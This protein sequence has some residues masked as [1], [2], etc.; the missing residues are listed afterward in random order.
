M[1]PGDLAT[2]SRDWQGY[3]VYAGPSCEGS[4][5]GMIRNH[6]EV[7]LI[8]SK[9]DEERDEPFGKYIIRDMYLILSP[10][11]GIGWVFASYLEPAP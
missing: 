5:I 1:S 11:V 10:S 8:L 7:V 4:V 3:N 9:R 2:A 6:A